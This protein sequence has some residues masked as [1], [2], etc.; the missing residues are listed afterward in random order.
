[1]ARDGGKIH[2]AT[3]RRIGSQSYHLLIPNSLMSALVTRYSSFRYALNSRL[4]RKLPS[5][6]CT[7]RSFFQSFESTTF[8]SVFSQNVTCDALSCFAPMMPRQFDK[9]TS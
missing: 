9:D 7:S 4:R 3:P 1:M 5:Q 2:G 6:Y 8:A